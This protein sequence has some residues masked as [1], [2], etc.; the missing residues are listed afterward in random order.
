MQ[1]IRR[2]ARI[3]FTDIEIARV[4]TCVERRE[5]ALAHLLAP[6]RLVELHDQVWLAGI[7]VGRRVVEGQVAVL[8]DPDKRDV[9]GRGGD[10]ATHGLADQLGVALAVDQVRA[11]ECPAGPIRRSCR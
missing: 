3:W 1:R 6:A 2:L 4:G 9:D 10:V 7:E 11:S 5:P 8:A